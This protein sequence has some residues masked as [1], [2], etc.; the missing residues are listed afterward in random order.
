MNPGTRGGRKMRPP[1]LDWQ[2]KNSRSRPGN[3][4]APVALAKLAKQIIDPIGSARGSS[5]ARLHHRRFHSRSGVE[6]ELG[7]L[8]RPGP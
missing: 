8:R 5:L 7:R 4:F 1:A 6:L 3:S 2:G